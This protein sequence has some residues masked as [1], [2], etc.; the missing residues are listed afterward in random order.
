VY[1]HILIPTDGSAASERA[2]ATGIAL[3]GAL[4]ARVTGFHA[5]PP[6]VPLV[7]GKQLAKAYMS[8][9]EREKAIEQAAARYLGVIERAAAKAGVACETM[10]VTSDLPADAIL[11]AARSRKCDLVVMA[12]HGRHG[13]AAML[14]GSETQKVLTLAK[15]PVL[16]HR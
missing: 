11:E 15:I 10:L 6:A 16:V 7:L 4:G 1:K 14:L 13:L 5:A 9:D 12:S 8:R 3:A 2:I